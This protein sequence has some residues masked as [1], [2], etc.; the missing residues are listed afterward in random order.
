MVEVDVR[1]QLAKLVQH[2]RLYEIIITLID[3]VLLIKRKFLNKYYQKKIE[4]KAEHVVEA[5]YVGGKSNVN[6]STKL[7]KNVNFNGMSVRGGGEV[8]F[9]DNFHSGTDC[10][11][12]T[13]NHNY[14]K[15][16]S[17]PY[18][19]TYIFEEVLIGCNVWLGS[20]VTVLPGVTIG[21][22]AIIQAGSTVTD[23]I[24]KGAIAGG[25]PA[26]VFSKRDMDHYEK[27]KSN[28]NFH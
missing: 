1:K 2:I 6:E 7:G 23:D 26:K 27:H 14:D 10:L 19:N 9:G 5:P 13:Q 16:D 8:K 20:R 25:H 22:G 17:V 21:E 11:I 4:Q 18:D 15:G 28:E 3:I 12:I 24:P